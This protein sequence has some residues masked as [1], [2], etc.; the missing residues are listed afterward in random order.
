[1]S[2]QPEQM[3]HVE[4]LKELS[5]LRKEL[6]DEARLEILRA[7]LETQQQREIREQD[8]AL[9]V[10]K[11]QLETSRDAF[12]Q[13][14]DFAPVSYLT[15][16]PNGL[17]LGINLTGC[18]LLEIDRSK[19]IG[20]PLYS[21]VIGLDRLIFLEHMRRCR[22]RIGQT[23]TEVRLKTR[24]GKIVPVL[25][26]SRVRRL[27]VTEIPT[28]V[29]DQTERHN[30]QHELRSLYAELEVRVQQRTAE[31]QQANESLRHEIRQ[32]E[33]A[34][35]SLQETARRK[36][37][38]LAMLG[39]ELRNPLAP[40]QHAIEIWKLSD[41]TD[42]SLNEMRKIMSRQLNHMARIIDDLLDVSRISQGKI[43]LHQDLV[44]IST[45]TKEVI[46]DLDNQYTQKALQLDCD[47]PAEPVWV[48]GDETRLAQVISNLL[49]NAKKFTP[50]GG[51]VTVALKMV[52]NTARLIVRD[53]G[54]GIDAGMLREIFET[55]TQSHQSIDR[56]EGGL[57]LGLALVRG[58]VE[59]HGGSVYA[60]SEG[61]GRGSEFV[62][63][64]PLAVPAVLPKKKTPAPKTP[65]RFRI[66]II[67]D[68]HDVLFTMHA[69]LSRLGHDVVTADN[70]EEGIRLAKEVQPDVVF[71]D[72]GL[73]GM[74]GYEVARNLRKEAALEGHPLVALTGYGQADDQQRA[75]E[76]GFDQ[77]ITKPVPFDELCR[78]LNEL[79]PGALDP[80]AHR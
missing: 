21:F 64:L 11:R 37:E 20:L 61:L 47:L 17:I 31:L 18:Q 35:T 54:V 67:D 19:V 55:F 10:A 56:R 15:L 66:L 13:L 68:Q 41:P 32:R 53:S 4:L 22:V 70:G 34:E 5:R 1:M 36:D 3:S 26:S 25:L 59:L 48:R 30:A 38:F 71:S 50:P 8:A 24:G 42:P 51:Q 77:H 52:E 69:L 72:I 57:G 43:I 12:V 79:K 58:L 74:D 80:T 6:G 76:A 2:E 75:Y 73:P 16:D 63:R 33:A 9:Q 29:L 78:I 45:V 44:D 60:A 39:H 27:G 23:D 7:E 62:V 65:S 49:Q 14:Y 46:T 40:I 28:A